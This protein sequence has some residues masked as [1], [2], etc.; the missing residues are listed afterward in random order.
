[1]DIV[2]RFPHTFKK[3]D[4]IWVVVDR[5]TM[6][7]LF[8][9]IQNGYSVSKLAEIFRQEIIRLHGIPAAIVSDSDLRFISRFW[10]GLHKAWGIRLK[11]STAFH[12]HNDRQT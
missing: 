8:L 6:S 7:A 1:M 3:N 2:T 5:L 11:F 12:P 4:A 10:K 9:P